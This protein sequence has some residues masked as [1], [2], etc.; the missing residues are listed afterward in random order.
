M[1][2]SLQR[3]AFEVDPRV[4]ETR[5]GIETESVQHTHHGA[6]VLQRFQLLGKVHHE[7]HRLGSRER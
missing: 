3:L 7:S 4:F 1:T 2:V 6:V 5:D